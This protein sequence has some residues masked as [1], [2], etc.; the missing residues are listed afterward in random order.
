MP[1]PVTTGEH[2]AAAGGPAMEMDGQA[3][4]RLE[5]VAP[6]RAAGGLMGQ[7]PGRAVVVTGGSR[8]LG[9]SIAAAFASAGARV[10]IVGRNRHSLDSAT[11]WLSESTGSS[12]SSLVADL[13]SADASTAMAIRAADILGGVDVLCTN[14]GIYPERLLADMTVE[15]YN[16]VM[17][18]NVRGT[19]WA[20]KSCLPHLAA[21]K[22]GRIVIVSSITGPITGAPGWS[23]YGASKAA[24]LG[25]MRSAALECAAQGVTINA[26]APG[27]VDTDSYRDLPPDEQ[28]S[29]RAAVPLGRVGTGGE[30]AA[31]CMFLASRN[32]G[33]ITGQ[34]L[35]VDGGQ[36]LPEVPL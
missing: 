34:V 3:M 8:G 26:V 12:V 24:Q 14:A 19:I 21:S 33:F 35:V 15:D 13:R 11:D 9:L 29:I 16:D 25:F 10:L 23:H 36:T 18:T 4:G 27:S 7:V 28:R 30:V 22:Y 31:A 2:V 17:D 1:S 32:A 6:L 5:C 20:V